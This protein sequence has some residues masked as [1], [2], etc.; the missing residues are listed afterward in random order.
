MHV[1]MCMYAYYVCIFVCVYMYIRINVCMYA[2][3][4]LQLLRGS[5]SP[6]IA[7]IHVVLY[8]LIIPALLL[9]PDFDR[10]IE[11]IHEGILGSAAASLFCPNLS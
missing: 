9:Q 3:V 1:Y 10:N 5:C 6:R 8:S 2:C 11:Y 7:T 4:C